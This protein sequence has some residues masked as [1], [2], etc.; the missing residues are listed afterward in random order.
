MRGE[1]RTVL[2]LG[3]PVLP[4]LYQPCEIPR[5]LRIVQFVDFTGRSPHD[6]GALNEVLR[7]LAPATVDEPVSAAHPP[8]PAAGAA[9][10]RPARGGCAT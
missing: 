7:A 10:R 6:A 1:L 4:V 3:K 2:D 5:Q 8:R 9:G